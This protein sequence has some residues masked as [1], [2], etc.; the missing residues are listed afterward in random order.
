MKV[1]L[2]AAIV[3]LLIG[4]ET[5][6][7][8]GDSKTS[9]SPYIILNTPE[10]LQ[11]AYI[12][13]DSL[14]KAN[15]LKRSY[16]EFNKVF[17][18]QDE[19]STFYVDNNTLQLYLVY[20]KSTFK[21]LSSSS[22]SSPVSVNLRLRIH[23]WADSWLFINRYRFKLDNDSVLSIVPEKVKREVLDGGRI[24]EVGD[25]ILGGED[26]NNV[27]SIVNSKTVKMRLDGGEHYDERNLRR[28]ELVAAKHILD[29]Y[30][31]IASFRIHPEN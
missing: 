22:S 17:F 28:A 31:Q 10:E 19:S 30:D 2:L 29:V 4:C 16:D 27:R 6:S 14:P 26:L 1:F 9:A 5:K 20:D 13:L 18:F 24:S 8:Y 3:L 7:N 12:L 25:I 21:S 23:Y 11:K 15:H